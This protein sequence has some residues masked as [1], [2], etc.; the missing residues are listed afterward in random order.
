MIL[1]EQEKYSRANENSESIVMHKVLRNIIKRWW[2]FLIIGIAGGIAGL[3]YAIKQKPVYESY[4]SFALDEGGSQ[5]GGAGAM[6]LAAQLGITL[7]GAQD[8]FTGDNILEIMQSRRMIEGVLLSIDTFD[9]KPM[10]L[11]Q[12]F[13]ENE[14]KNNKGQ[15]TIGNIHF[16]PGETRKQFSYSKDSL[17]YKIF[18]V[19]KKDHIVARKPDRRL[20]IYEL[21]V[22]SN[23]E[24]L[25]K[26]FTDNLIDVTN[27]FYTEIRSKKS[28]ETLEILEN[29]VPD[30]KGK[31]EAT[32]TSKAAIQDANLNT[33]FASAE[34]PLLKAQS[35]TQVYGAAYAEMFKNLEMA[36]FQYLKSIPLMQV[37]DAADYPMKKITVS[38]FKMAIICSVIATFIFLLVFIIVS[39][40]RYK[41]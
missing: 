29:R 40:F 26:V 24:K 39:F 19:F 16:Y 6:G 38:K 14:L 36:R 11:I 33:A 20:N 41:S 1:E 15:N 37:I 32:I 23:N 9:N 27:R 5:S 21:M 25:S 30:M 34:V 35:N 10:T 18:L 3:I 28:K 2:L 22:T 17:L 8:V 13:L 31:L 4:L 7:G 12:F